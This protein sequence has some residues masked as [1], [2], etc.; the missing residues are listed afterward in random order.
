MSD[1]PELPPEL[2]AIQPTKKRFPGRPRKIQAAQ[3]MDELVEQCAEGIVKGESLRYATKGPPLGEMSADD[4][5]AIQRATGLLAEEFQGKI[6]KRIEEFDAKL[7]TK[8]S[9]VSD[10][11][12]DKLKEYAKN[13]KLTASNIAFALSVTEAN[14][15]RLEGKNSIQNASVNI[16]ITQYNGSDPNFDR[17]K[18][19]AALRPKTKSVIN[20]DAV[21]STQ[22]DPPNP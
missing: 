14:R 20:V 4:R 19:L 21:E 7:A 9:E 3:S 12:A 17:E 16:A 5:K 11:L 13:G 1:N 6:S 18:L 22:D 10:V 8:L 2:A 15:A